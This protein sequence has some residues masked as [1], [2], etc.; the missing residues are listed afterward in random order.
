MATKK[1]T[2]TKKPMSKAAQ[3]VKF[4]EGE[5]KGRQP[6]RGVVR[7][8]VNIN[9]GLHRKFK[10]AAV[11]RGQTMGAM[12]EDWIRDNLADKAVR[13]ARA[14]LKEKGQF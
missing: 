9:A 11:S 5:P 10:L 7:L 6:P 2:T 4:A 12:L 8:T 14:Y 13:D 3:A 1:A